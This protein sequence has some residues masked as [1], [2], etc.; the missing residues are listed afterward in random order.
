M[1]Y[2]EWK[3]CFTADMWEEPPSRPKVNLHVFW[4]HAKKN[5]VGFI[6]SDMPR[7]YQKEVLAAALTQRFF[8]PRCYSSISALLTC[9]NIFTYDKSGNGKLEMKVS[10]YNFH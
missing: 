7:I 1:A 6:K 8:I 5:S 4:A 2:M 9:T 10:A 3:S